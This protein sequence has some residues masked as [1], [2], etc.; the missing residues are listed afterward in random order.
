MKTSAP[1]TL[2]LFVRLIIVHYGIWKGG[3]KLA[4]KP[5]SCTSLDFMQPKSRENCLAGI[6]KTSRVLVSDDT[7]FGNLY[8]CK[9][10]EAEWGWAWEKG[11]VTIKGS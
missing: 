7:D 5:G 2:P 6:V 9:L 3:G 8:G 4:V 1:L 10:R 11:K